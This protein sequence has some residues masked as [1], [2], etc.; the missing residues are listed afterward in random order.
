MSSPNAFEN[1][2]KWDC[3][4]ICEI[5]FYCVGYLDFEYFKVLHDSIGEYA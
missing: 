4:V 5:N 2:Q 3:N 1:Q